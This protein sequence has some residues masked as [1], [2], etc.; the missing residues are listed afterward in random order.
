MSYLKKYDLPES[1]ALYIT[2]DPETAR[3]LRN[4]QEAVLIYLHEGNRGQDFSEFLYAVEDP[5]HIEPEFADRVYR[6]QKGLPWEILQ[7]KRCIVRETIPEDVEDFFLIYSDP[8]ITKYM[9]GLYPDREQEKEYIREYIEKVYTFY[10]YGIWTVLEKSGGAVI[11]RAGFA[12]REGYEEPELGFIIARPWQRQGYAE[13]VCRAV[14][15]YGWEALGFPCVQ[16][17]VE[18]RNEASLKL[19]GKLGFR[20]TGLVNLQGKPHI[21]LLASL[22]GAGGK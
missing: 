15:N 11:G 4:A 12:C 19:C 21:R 3:A 17:M 10:E 16:A 9:E 8:A 18:P 20:E 2:D 5:E 13:E 7:T 6:R 1:A 14:L 22:G